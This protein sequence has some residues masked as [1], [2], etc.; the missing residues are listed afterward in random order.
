MSCCCAVTVLSCVYM[1][2]Q[3]WA[4]VLASPHVLRVADACATAEDAA[5]GAALA[6]K[7]AAFVSQAVGVCLSGLHE[8]Q[9]GDTQ[10]GSCW[11]G[12]LWGAAQHICGTLR[13][14]S[15]QLSPAC[16]LPWLSWVIGP[17]LRH[18]CALCVM[19]VAAG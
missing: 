4:R 10:V 19:W 7:G 17:P 3:E 14:G 6:G 2:V 13:L 16:H 8:W 15:M 9:H 18:C 5:L 12:G 1:L 11:R